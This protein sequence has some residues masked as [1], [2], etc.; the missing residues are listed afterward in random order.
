MF[1]DEWIPLRIPLNYNLNKISS[2]LRDILKI[3][4]Q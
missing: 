4:S 1:L 2:G 3:I